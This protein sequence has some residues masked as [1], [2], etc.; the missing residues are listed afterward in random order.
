MHRQ[1]VLSVTAIGLALSA[2]ACCRPTPLAPPFDGSQQ[3]A[4]TGS[5]LVDA[6]LADGAAVTPRDAAASDSSYAGALG[7]GEFRDPTCV[8]QGVPWG[9]TI[10]LG[11]GGQAFIARL[12]DAGCES[13]RDYIPCVGGRVACAGGPISFCPPAISYGVGK[14]FG[15]HPFEGWDH[16]TLEPKKGHIGLSWSS[17]NNPAGCKTPGCGDNTQ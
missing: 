5:N 12:V 14:E 7:P 10:P 8:G 3:D 13:P 15:S 6:S 1:I 2:A 17:G 4:G 16:C 9:Q 11:S